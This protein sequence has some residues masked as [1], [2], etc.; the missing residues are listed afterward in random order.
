MGAEGETI[1]ATRA[2]GRGVRRS[3]RDRVL[4]GV[5]G[6]LGE[7]AG[8][9]PALVRLLFVV[10]A[11]AGGVGLLAYLA[12]AVLLPEGDDEADPATCT[13]DGLAETAAGLGTGLLAVAIPVGLGLLVLG[14]EMGWVGALDWRALA[15]LLAAGLGAALLLGR[16]CS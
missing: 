3:E 14:R 9:R 5:A 12:L 6:G 13:Y 10:G 4:L 11:L 1:M 7:F 15:A 8:Q 16:R 2:D